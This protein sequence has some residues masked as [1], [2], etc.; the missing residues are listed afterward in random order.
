MCGCFCCSG[1]TI[2]E[3]SKKNKTNRFS[4]KSSLAAQ[5]A[6]DSLPSVKGNDQ[7]K[8]DLPYFVRSKRYLWET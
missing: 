7:G 1:Q 5:I 4:K 3:Q 6:N 8:K 2:S